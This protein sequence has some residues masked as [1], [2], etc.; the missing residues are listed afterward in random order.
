MKSFHQYLEARGNELSTKEKSLI[1]KRIADISSNYHEKI[2]LDDIFAAL[3]E[4]QVSPVQEDQTPWSGMLLGGKECG[5]PE[6]VKQRAT[7]D[8]MRNGQV[9]NHSDL[10]LM[11]CKMPSGK[12]EIVS[13]VS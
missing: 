3:R 5:H 4:F 6:A 7:I 10:L 8:L 2:P 11:W 13:Y 9:L 1:N 12:Y